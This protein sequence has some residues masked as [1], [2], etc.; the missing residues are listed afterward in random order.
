MLSA[1]FIKPS[2]GEFE[3]VKS[4][5]RSVFIE[6][7]KIDESEEWDSHDEKSSNADFVVVFYG[8]IPVGTGRIIKCNGFVK[9]G[10]IAV[11]KQYRRLHAGAAVVAALKEKAMQNGEAD[12]RVDAQVQAAPFYEKQGFKIISGEIF[13]DAGIDHVAMKLVK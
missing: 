6:E 13:K 5:R 4:I 1:K 10:R 12:I 3:F 2:D 7:Q 8:S 9:L 11:L